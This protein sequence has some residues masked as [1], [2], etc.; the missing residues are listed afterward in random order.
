MLIGALLLV[1]SWSQFLACHTL[2]LVR[3]TGRHCPKLQYCV[4]NVTRR[5]IQQWLLQQMFRNRNVLPEEQNLGWKD[6]YHH[7][8]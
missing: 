4:S 3:R 6:A 7:V 5:W 1:R 8:N 2:F